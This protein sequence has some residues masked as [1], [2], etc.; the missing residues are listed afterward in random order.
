MLYWKIYV[1]YFNF[2]NNIYDLDIIIVLNDV[3]W[4]GLIFYVCVISDVC[5]VWI[6]GLVG[7]GGCGI[8]LELLLLILIYVD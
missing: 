3:M 6:S 2:R 4:F 1:V 5:C 7:R 8:Y